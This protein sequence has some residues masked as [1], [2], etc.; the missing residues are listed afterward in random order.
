MRA[1]APRT[2]KSYSTTSRKRRQCRIPLLPS[3]SRRH[4][5]SKPPAPPI[6]RKKATECAKAD[7]VDEAL[8]LLVAE[9]EAPHDWALDPD[10]HHLVDGVLKRVDAEGAVR[11]GGEGVDD[12]S[13]V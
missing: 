2:K 13:R 5:P 6:R 7:E 11:R 12:T 1:H 3:P 8:L 4:C 10:V 9:A